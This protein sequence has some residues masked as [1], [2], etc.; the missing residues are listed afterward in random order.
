MTRFLDCIAAIVSAYPDLQIESACIQPGGQYSDALLVNDEIIFCFPLYTD[1]AQEI[2]I[3]KSLRGHLPLTIPDPI[4]VHLDTENKLAFYGYPRIPGEVTAIEHLESNYDSAT[5]DRLA[6]QI[7]QFLKALHS[8]PLEKIGIELVDHDG[9]IQYT[10]MYQK[11]KHY[12]FSRMRPDAREKITRHFED[13]LNNASQYVYTPVL[14]HGDFGLVHVLF[15]PKEVKFT[16]VINFGDTDLGDP[17]V[18]FAGLYG[19]SDRS[20]TFARR[21]FAA[22]P[23]LEAMTQR[24]HFHRG[25]FALQEALFGAEQSDDGALASG[26][27]DYV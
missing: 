11:I 15:D 20:A 5:C 7:G 12:L 23:E 1:I 4:Y 24:M 2:A 6:S 25:T 14:R 17:A 26:L 3:L 19:Y 10:E 13:Y 27:E 16:A 8:H 22:Y 18:D 9:V 21:M